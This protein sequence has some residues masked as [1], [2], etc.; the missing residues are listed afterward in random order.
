MS[1]TST[2]SLKNHAR[3]DPLYH[4]VLTLILFLNLIYSVVHLVR[5]LSF[6]SAWCQ[7]P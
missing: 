6:R 1:K 4:I 5:H 2:Q 3:L 7:R